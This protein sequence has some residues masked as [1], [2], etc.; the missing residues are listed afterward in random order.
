MNDLLKFWPSG[1][2]G[3]KGRLSYS[4]GVAKN[5]INQKQANQF[6]SQNFLVNLAQEKSI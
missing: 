3:D 1:G 2:R 6:F 5:V 4:W